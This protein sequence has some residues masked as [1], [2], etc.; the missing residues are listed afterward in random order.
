MKH[1]LVDEE[2]QW[3]LRKYHWYISSNGYVVS[4]EAGKNHKSRK[5]LYLQRVIMNAPKGRQVDHI[6]LNKLDNRRSNLRL[7]SESQNKVNRPAQKNNKLGQKDI[8][9]QTVLCNG[10][11]YRYFTIDI[12]VNGINKRW[13]RKTLEEAISV[14]NAKIREM[15]GEFGRLT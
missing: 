14:R 1:I 10:K 12:Q 7:A 9:I 5:K 6:N 15:H 13:Y 8:F 4:Q 2:D 3:L 11:A